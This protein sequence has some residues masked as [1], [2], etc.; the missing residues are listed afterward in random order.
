M[1][2]FGSYG[3]DK[4]VGKVSSAICGKRVTAVVI[5]AVTSNQD[6]EVAYRRAMA[7]DPWNSKILGQLDEYHC[8]NK[9]H[10]SNEECINNNK[11]TRCI[12]CTQHLCSLCQLKNDFREVLCPLADMTKPE[13]LFLKD[14]IYS[15]IGNGPS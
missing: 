2:V 6:T 5:K 3:V 15:L 9:K 1:E 4:S 10:S 8:L 12:I 7:A 14:I 13:H 11:V